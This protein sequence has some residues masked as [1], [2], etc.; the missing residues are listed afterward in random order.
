MW[1]IAF[2]VPTK[3]ANE[4]YKR[5]PTMAADTYGLALKY[6]A[7]LNAIKNGK[8]QKTPSAI[9]LNRRY[10]SLWFVIH[11]CD[12]HNAKIPEISPHPAIGNVIGKNIVDTRLVKR[13]IIFLFF[14]S[15]YLE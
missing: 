1:S 5:T 4:G 10:V 3:E 9:A 14:Q 12:V 2:S 15:Y 11:P 13:S 7:A 6:F 8:K